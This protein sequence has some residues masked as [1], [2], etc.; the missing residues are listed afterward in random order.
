MRKLLLGSVTLGCVALGAATA[1]A[2]VRFG[3]NLSWGSDTEL[4]LGARLG[5]GLGSVSNRSPVEGYAT[6]DYYFPE[7]F[8]YWELS[9]NVLYRIPAQSSLK[10]YAGAG[11]FYGYG[12]VDDSYTPPLRLGAPAPGLSFS[13]ARLGEFGTDSGFG[14]NLMGGLRFA[15]VGN[16][17]PFAEVKLAIASGTQLVLAGGVLFG[18]P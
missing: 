9:G 3:A 16:V 13:Q 5:F 15:A 11:L 4:G 12:S 10:P 8:N 14:F 6:F 2:Q 1:E 7:G 17:Q 18:R